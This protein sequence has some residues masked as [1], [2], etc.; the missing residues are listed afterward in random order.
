MGAQFVLG[1]ANQI[2]TPPVGTVLFGY[3]NQRKST[4]INDDLKVN[5]AAF[6]NGKPEALLI[7]A[8]LCVIN[9]AL[10]E[11]ICLLIAEE[12]SISKDQIIICAIHTHSGPSL[13]AQAGW[14]EADDTYIEN[15]FIP[16]TLEAVKEAI[17]C[18]EPALMGVGT[19]NSMVGVN[20]RE[21]LED[22]T[23]VLGQNPYGVYDPTMTVLS[24]VSLEKKP[25]LNIVH[26]GAHP[27]SAGPNPEITR[28]WP[29]YM[30]D[31]LQAETGAASFFI[32]GAEGDIGPRLSNGKTTGD[33]EQTCEVGALAA[34]D[35]VRAYKTIKEYRE[36]SFNTYRDTISVPYRPF[37]TLE[38]AQAELE[39]F[40]DPALL[41]EVAVLQYATL[42]ERI[43]ILSSGEER[44]THFKV[45]QT[46]FAFNSVVLVPFSNEM[47]SEITLRLRQY[48]PFAHTLAISNANGTEGYLPTRDQLCRGGYEVDSFLY[49]GAYALVE[50]ADDVFIGEYLRMIKQLAN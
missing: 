40:G 25:L 21:L 1:T 29:G 50:N 45:M 35:V 13:A 49:H 32:N 31:R 36:V 3:P 34:L 23:V 38:E 30:V 14:G 10:A 2:I 15:I 4:S 33:I 46:L 47:F 11:W 19:T 16:R 41:K 6:G 27:T 43:K 12:T 39:S 17:C 20:R 24:F 37:P 28:D 9:A 22:G 18:V 7:S 8:D 48:S 42:K 44:E 26:Y 5:V